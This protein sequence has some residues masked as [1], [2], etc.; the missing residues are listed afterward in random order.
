MGR[1]IAIDDG[2]GIDT[3]GKRTPIFPDG[4]RSEI[5]KNYMNENLFNRAVAKYLDEEL[6]RCGFR[7]LMV[8]P[9]DA[10]DSLQ[11]RVNR[12]DNAKADMYISIH[13]NANSGQWGTWGGTETLTYKLT[14]ESN[15][16]GRIIHKHLM[17][18]TP[19]RDRGVKDGSGLFVI[20]N[21]SM[22][23]VLVECAFMDNLQEAKL[24]LS[25]AFRRECAREI[26]MGICEAYGVAYVAQPAPAPNPTPNPAQGEMYRVRLYWSDEKTQKGAFKNLDGAKKLADDLIN[27]GD[28]KVFNSSGVIVYDPQPIKEDNVWYRVR[29]TW[30][31]AKS[32]IGAFHELEGAKKLADE[33]VADGYKVFNDKGEAI[34]TPVQTAPKPTPTPAP[35]EQK[36]Q[37]QQVETHEGHNDI[38]GKFGVDAEKMIAFVKNENPDAKDIEEIVNQF[39]EVGN[40][41][42]IRG[43]I[44]FCQSIIETGWFKFDG[45]TA[46]TPEQHNYCGMGVTSKGIKGNEFA[47]VKDG[48][49]AQVQH[50]FAYASKEEMPVGEEVVDPR[51]KYVTRGIAPHWEDLSMRW[52]MNKDYGKHIVELYKQLVDFVYEP[53]ETEE[54]EK[55]PVVEDEIPKDKQTEKEHQENKSE[56][57]TE[58][59][60]EDVIK[61]LIDYFIEK[62]RE[63]FNKR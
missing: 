20:K 46:V 3:A 6:K 22:T 45:G 4:T 11:T 41:Y 56:A 8:A 33:R 58:G 57:T 54:P 14:G 18:G 27:E 12:A 21:T 59:N 35:E 40:K 1:L 52:A 60:H 25:D 26:A 48:V 42:G 43:D 47:T 17:K 9:T 15:R 31:D 34:Y 23:A 24:L 32:Q 50:L 53:K 7:T 38:I 51:F 30:E 49:T 44:A 63:L 61:R 19:L 29:K 5:G 39:I 16:V 10:D 55:E 2:H 13:A 28:Y 37:E 36:E 62:L